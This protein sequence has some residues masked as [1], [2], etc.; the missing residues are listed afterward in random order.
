M[1]RRFQP[2]LI[3]HALALL[4]L[5]GLLA[6]WPMAGF[7]GHELIATVAIFAILCMSLD[8]LA[9][10]AGLVSLAHAAFFGAGAYLYALATVFWSWPAPAS[11]VTAVIGCGLI[12]LFVGAV[13]V[14]THGLFFIM[15][16]L[17]FG[18]I[19]YEI[20][21]RNREFGGSDGLSGVPRLD[22]GG[23]GIDLV[24]SSAFSL[25]TLLAATVIYIL[26]AYVVGT[27]F[28]KALV[29]IRESERRARAIGIPVHAHRTAA[30]AAAGAIA[31]FA[32][33]LTAQHIGLVTPQLLHWTTSGEILVM[34]I[35][36]GLGTLAGPAIGAVFL[37][38]LRHEVSAYTDYWGFWLG[39]MLVV[40]V[41]LGS[42]G[43]AGW[44]EDLL[45]RR[46]WKG[47]RPGESNA[48]R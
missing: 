16:T 15:I 21:L 3:R 47:D 8:L 46:I 40:V 33:T 2:E 34:A 31:G 23:I 4:L 25:T 41:M 20:V 5:A 10:Y 1:G 39:A 35:L 30:F 18:E 26:L 9:G 43:I 19:G 38:L 44:I 24:D 28:G 6:W 29:G 12:A 42:R 36:G 7:F 17:A 48:T 32:G 14:R 13:A 22:L 11:M 27:P 37:T 45:E